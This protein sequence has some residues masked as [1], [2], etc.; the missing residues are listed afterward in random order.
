MALCSSGAHMEQWSLTGGSFRCLAM[1][2]FWM[3]AASSSV[4]PLSHSVVYEELAIAEPQ[5]KVCQS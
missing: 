1:S 3:L 4:L 5:P 2:E